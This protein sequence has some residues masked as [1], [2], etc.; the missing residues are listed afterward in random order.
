MQHVRQCSLY[1]NIDPPSWLTARADADL[2]G[3]KKWELGY[4]GSG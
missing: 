4:D 3:G 1:C 2:I